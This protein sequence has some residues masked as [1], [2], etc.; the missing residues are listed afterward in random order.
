MLRLAR[1]LSAAILTVAAGPA[2]SAPVFPDAA[3]TTIV[4]TMPLPTDPADAPVDIAALLAAARGIP[5]PVCALAV[6]GLRNGGWGRVDAPFS[7]VRDTTFADMGRERRELPQGDV[8]RLVEA[9]AVSDPCV[10]AVAVQLLGEQRAE[11]VTAPLVER[12]AAADPATRAVAAEG[13]GL[14]EADSAVTPL[15][16]VLRDD[17]VPVRANGAWALGRIGDGRALAPLVATVRDAD[18]SVREA[19]VV[20]VGQLDST[21]AS[22]TLVRVLRDDASPRVRR[23]AA[24]ALAE[25]EAHDE[26]SIDALGN[27]LQ[28][29][30]DAQVRE[31]AAWALGENESHGAV[32]ALT[33]A[34]RSDAEERVRETAAWAL[35]ESEDRGAV[36]ALS[37]AVNGDASVRVRS[38]AAWALGQFGDELSAAPAGLVRL[39]GDADHRARLTAA[40]ALG[41]I[42]DSSIRVPVRQALAR[43]SNADVRRALVRALI[44]SGEHSEEAMRELLQS[45]DPRVR[46]AA[47][48]GLAGRERLDPWPW[49]MPRP[50]PFP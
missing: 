6:G 40:W 33:A 44:R 42:R 9:L 30:A 35:G 36:A 38:T 11:R 8:D 20:A 14:A 48:R 4:V 43:E 47:V 34:L 25:I 12:L 49:P 15:V 46:E 45:S 3:S 5:A 22:A 39:L 27:A 37:A 21:S 29:D 24:W 1:M 16:R 7:P 26:A 19:A 2:P 41:E 31:M 32:A 13:L 17:A 10:R 23:V 50:R 18:A 28:H